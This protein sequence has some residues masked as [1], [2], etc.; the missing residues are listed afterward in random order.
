M[1]SLLF[2]IGCQENKSK[3]SQEND[4]YSFYVGTYTNQ[5][6]KGIYHYQLEK[7]GSLKRIGLASPSENP[8]YLTR[9]ADKKFLLATNETNINATGSVESFLIS[10]DSLKFIS[11]RPSGGGAPCYVAINK[12]DFVL[13]A[14][15]TGGNIGLLKLNKNGELSDLLN[16]QQHTGSGIGDRQK[17]P[18]AHSVWFDPSGKGIISVDL[19]TNELWFSQIDSLNQKIIPSDPST[20]K[21]NP[22]AGPRHLAFHPNGKWIYVINELDCTLTFLQKNEKGVYEKGASVSTLPPDYNEPNTSADI[23]ISSDG[24]FVYASNRGHNSIAIFE[25]DPQNGNLKLQA[26][27]STHGE[28]PRNFSLSPDEDFLLVANQ[29]SNNIVSFK[30]DKTSGLL[31]YVSEIKAPNPVCIL[32]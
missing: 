17:E 5:D 15:Y 13:V 2:L 9:S 30:R 4:P 20:L 8:S 24:K 6:S 16:V 14:N 23:H 21:M 1:I 22:G 32:F 31:E 7:D 3:T 25:V 12:D 11:R 10:G 27:Q 26:F 28:G 18:H 29:Y 19:G